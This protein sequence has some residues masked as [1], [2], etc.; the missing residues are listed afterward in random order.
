[1]HADNYRL[2]IADIEPPMMGGSICLH[3][4]FMLWYNC[5]VSYNNGISIII[6]I[7]LGSVLSVVGGYVCVDL[8]IYQ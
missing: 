7:L 4:Q 5:Y 8:R 1:M 3:S 2:Y 6:L